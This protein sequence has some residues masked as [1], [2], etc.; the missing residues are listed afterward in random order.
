[1]RS[2]PAGVQLIVLGLIGAYLGRL[3]DEVRGRPLYILREILDESS[4][5]R[6]VREAHYALRTTLLTADATAGSTLSPAAWS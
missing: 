2:G 1:M 6:W 4:W 3:S 5:L